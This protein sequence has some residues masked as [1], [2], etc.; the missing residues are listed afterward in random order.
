[1]KKSTSGFTIVELLV[2]IV[3]IGIL[4]AI[5]I[6]AYNGIQKRA[7]AAAQRTELRSLGQTANLLAISKDASFEDP[8]TWRRALEDANL[9]DTA[10]K[11]GVDSDKSIMICAKGDNYAIG[12]WRPYNGSD[13][14]AK[15]VIYAF[16]GNVSSF[17]W[18]PSVS[19]ATTLD[20]FCRQMITLTGVDV[21]SSTSPGTSL[22]SWSY[23]DVI[24]NAAPLP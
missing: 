24:R 6:V 13:P 22:T 15:E 5:T 10:S 1:M 20:R 17:T 9:Y 11:N 19:A 14:D 23:N 16:N 4:A 18:N 8:R 7:A 3:V 12:G 2:V 21:G